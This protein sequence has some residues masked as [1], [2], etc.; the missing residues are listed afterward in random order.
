[1]PKLNAP[2]EKKQPKTEPNQQKTVALIGDSITELSTYPQ[3]LAK[4]LGPTYTIGNFGA[5]GTTITLNSANPYKYTEALT[6]AKK[7]E[8][9]IVVIMLGTNDAEETVF[10]ANLIADYLVLIEQF[11][12]LEKKPTV[13]L[14]KPPPIFSSWGGLSSEVLTKEILP[15]IEQIA[16]TAN[17]ILIDIFSVLQ[18]SSYFFDGVHPNDFGGKLIAEVIYHTLAMN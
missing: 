9:E 14:V 13:Y 18:D 2:Q 15:A 6:E 1:M 3:N 11:T 10:Q 17:L 16:K 8:P 4:L 5:C 12:A 7:S